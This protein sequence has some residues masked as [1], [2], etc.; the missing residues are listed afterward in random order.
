MSVLVV[1]ILAA[2][3][4]VA[5]CVLVERFLNRKIAELQVGLLYLHHASERD[6]AECG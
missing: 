6:M 4:T 5:I 2:I 3:A 1:S